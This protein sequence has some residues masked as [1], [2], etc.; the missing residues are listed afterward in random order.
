[1]ENHFVG[2]YG[3]VSFIFSDI[4]GVDSSFFLPDNKGFTC[5]KL[6]KKKKLN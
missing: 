6:K 5:K 3:R 2:L 1:M 4:F